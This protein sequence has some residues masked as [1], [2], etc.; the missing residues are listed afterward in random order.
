MDGFLR[1]MWTEKYWFFRILFAWTAFG[2][3]Y[4]AY[5]LAVGGDPELAQFRKDCNGRQLGRLGDYNTLPEQVKAQAASKVIVL[6]RCGSAF[7]RAF[8]P[9]GRWFDAL[10]HVT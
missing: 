10:L 9:V 1:A 7:A 8:L 4:M 6:G 5:G 3:C 2:I